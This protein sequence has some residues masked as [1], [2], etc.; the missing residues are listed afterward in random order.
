MSLPPYRTGPPPAPGRGSARPGIGQNT[1]TPLVPWAGSPPQPR[2]DALG[3]VGIVVVGVI[4]VAA[5]ALLGVLVGP[6]AAVVGGLLALL[7]LGVVLLAIRWLDRWEPEPAGA[8]WFAFLWGS[9][10]SVLAALLGNSLGAG[11]LEAQTGDADQ[12]LFLTASV[13]APVVE[14]SVKAFGVLILFIARRRYFDG[15]VDGMV[16][17]ATVAGG[18]AFSENILYFG[19]AADGLAAVFVARAVFSP[20]AHVL[21]TA[22]VGLALGIAAQRGTSAAA[23]V[24]FPVGLLVAISLHALWNASTALGEGFLVVYVVVQVPLF[25]AAIGLATWLRRVEARLVRLRLT[26]YASV[27]WF[28]PPEVGMLSSLSERRRARAWAQRYGPGAHAAMR[29]FQ[30]H[31]T[32]LA[33]HR[34]RLLL[35]RADLPARGSE[36]TLLAAISRDR[37][38]FQASVAAAGAAA[39]RR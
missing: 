23:V 2:S 32:D 27:G 25:L 28:S 7:P 3:V 39:P 14:E 22:C 21:F 29:G 6:R 26:E 12:T 31:A 34:H 8:L 13:V 37:A 11:Y 5:L 38:A 15:P 9:G 1:V 16:Y 33:Y 35:G 19:Q 17:A 36:A 30:R 18:F 20:F 24:A 10:A 4:A